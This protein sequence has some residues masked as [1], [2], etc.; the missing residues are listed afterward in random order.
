MEKKIRLAIAGVGN[1]ASSLVQGLFYYKDAKED[2]G[3]IPGLMHLAMGGYRVDDIEPVAAF[4]VD[5]RKVGKDLG[6]AIFAPP[7]NTE[8]FANVP[9]LGIEVMMGPVLDG[10]PSH[11][12]EFVKVADKKAVEIADILKSAKADILVNLIPTGSAKATRCYADACVKEAKV[13]FVNGIPELIACDSEYQRIAEKNRVPLVGDDV[14]S[15]VGATILHRTLVDLFQSRGVKVKKS[16]QL[17][18]GGNTD[19]V[20]L[21]NR[22]KTKEMTK[23]SA[24]KSLLPYEAELS[25]GFGFLPILKDTKIAVIL[26]EGEKFGGMPIR[27]KAE[28]EVIDSPNSAGVLIDA[29]R[30]AKIGMERRVGGALTSASAYFMKH[31]PKQF[32][33]EI[34]KAMVEEFIAGKRER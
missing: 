24:I 23:L 28:L 25:A 30:C 6:E 13:G 15:Q 33:D 21:V 14:K 4:D 5:D 18:Y 2:V 3:F 26:L 16:Y 12:Q 29:I 20:N 7:N 22:G 17:N 10:A 27:I 19:F 1:C 32:P 31:P 11:L 9:K 34:A 8:K